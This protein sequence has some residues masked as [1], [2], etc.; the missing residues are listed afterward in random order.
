MLNM[1]LVLL[2]LIL[3]LISVDLQEEG[4]RESMSTL[5]HYLQTRCLPLSFKM[6]TGRV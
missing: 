1:E 4:G 6:T 2:V 5:H 3:L